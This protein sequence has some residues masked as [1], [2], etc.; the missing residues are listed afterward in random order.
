MNI[1]DETS[2]IIFPFLILH[3]AGKYENINKVTYEQFNA[4]VLPVHVFG[5]FITKYIVSGGEN[6]TEGLQMWNGGAVPCHL[7][8]L[9]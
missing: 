7:D 4:N 8:T 9:V 3:W 2:R 1:K 6:A 5:N